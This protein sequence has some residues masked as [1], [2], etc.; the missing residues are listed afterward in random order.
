MQKNIFILFCMIFNLFF[1]LQ[2][3]NAETYVTEVASITGTIVYSCDFEAANPCISDWVVDTPWDVT[4]EDSYSGTQSLT[5]SAGSFYSDNYDGSAEIALNLTTADRPLLSFW[6]RYNLE[7]YADFGYVEVSMDGTNWKALYFVTGFSGANWEEVKVDLSEY[8]Y[9]NIWL[10]FRLVTNGSVT[11]DGW[12]VDDVSITANTTTLPYP[13]FDDMESPASKNNWI[14]STWGIIA[15]DSHSG[16]HSFTD[17]PNGGAMVDTSL[18]LS[19]TF[20]LSTS[21]NPQLSFWHRF[22]WFYGSLRVLLSHDS[23]HNW[24][25]LASYDWTEVSTWTKAQ[26][27]LSSYTGLSNILIKFE[28]I[29]SGGGYDGWYI[30][31]VLIDEACPN[32]LLS[33]SNP[34]EHSI[35]LSWTQSNCTDF[36]QYEIYRSTN[37]NVTRSDTLIATIINPAT[38]AYTD[39]NIPRAGTTYYYKIFILDSQELYNQGNLTQNTT[40]WGITQIP[41]GSM[42]DMESGDKW[43]NDLPWDLTTASA[44]SGTHSWK[45]NPGGSY[46]NNQDISLTT[47]LDLGLGNRPLL[48]FWH[49]YNL[50]SYADFGYVE[51]SM[52]GTN[53]K[54]LYFVTGFSGANWEEVKVDLSEYAYQNIWLRFRL[55]TNGSV[56]YDGWYVDD[57]SITANTTTLPYPF[58][59]DMESPAS[60]NNWI[61]STWGIIASDSHSG[62]HSFTDSPNGGAMVDTS[63]VLSGTFDL[64]TSVNPQLSFWHRFPWF[65]GSLRVL[66]SHDSGHNWTVLASYDWTEVSTWTKAQIDLSSY[67]GLSNILIKFEVIPS[68]GGYDGWYIDDVMIAN[69]SADIS[70]SPTS[71]DFGNINVGSQSPAQ[72]F[73]VTNKGIADLVISTLS[74]TGA[75]ASEFIKQNDNCSGMTLVS[76]TTCTV[77]AVFAPTS[78]GSKSANL[79]IPSNDPDTPILNV[80]LNGTAVS[81]SI[82]L[83]ISSLSVPSSA[84]ACQVISISDTTKNQGTGSA[85]ASTT[86]FYLSTDATYNRGDIYIGRRG[87]LVLAADASSSGRTRVTIPSS[88]TPGSYYIIAVAD[89]DRVVTESNE[90]NNN[91]TRAIT[92][93]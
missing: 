13:F 48:S 33:S 31:D 44:H 37:P 80:P 8:A 6:H 79:S 65:Y 36:S 3:I 9:Q 38:T 47:K 29:P 74:L 45:T 19:G 49:R 53:W 82:D 26:I 71:K 7:S 86:K 20:D 60:K 59:D 93:Q 40:L 88:T 75:N 83:I 16:T 34:T 84:N 35:D 57:V 39:T 46:S 91:R 67:T 51:V 68:G 32:V 4:I 89:A 63:L 72:V 50:E 85:G 61:A 1:S 41:I 87:V 22:P 56:T 11:Y 77:E 90:K 42:D 43:G 78:A 12:Y 64:S 66:L 21:V 25:V 69:A 30:D 55:V 73:T 17:S 2:K 70:V 27:D 28:V 18:V 81:G 5:D 54:A 10:R 92:I 14:A 62:T 24:T 15:S 76:F 52:D 23:G 58:F